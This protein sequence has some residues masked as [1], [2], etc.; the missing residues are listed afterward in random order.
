MLNGRPF[1]FVGVNM[2]GA[3]SDPRIYAC[4]PYMKNPDVELDDWF[5]RARQETNARVIRFWGFQRYTNGGTD[6][7]ALDRVIRLAGAYGFKV[8]PVLENQHEECTRGGARSDTWYAGGYRQQYGGYPLSYPEY[9]RRI[10]ERYR[11]EPAIFAWMLMNEAESQSADDA[12]KLDALYG[13]A[14]DMSAL[15]K[16]LDPNHLVTLGVVGGRQLGVW[17]SYRAL[18]ALPGI[19]FLDY[20]DY[21]ANDE[22]LPGAPAAATVLVQTRLFSQDSDWH[23]VQQDYRPNA[24]GAWET[25][26]GVLP[27]GSQPFRFAGLAFDA[28]AGGQPADIYVDEVQIGDRIYDF[29]DGTAQGWQVDGPATIEAIT[30]TSFAGN[31]ALKL[32]FIKPGG[33]ILKLPA[34]PT[35][36]PGTP[37]TAHV[38]V[39]A[40]ASVGNTGTL[41]AALETARE[42]NKPLVVGESGMT[43]CASESGSAVETP[44]TRAQKFDAKLQ[45]FFAAGG[46][47]YL[48]WAWHPTSDCSYEFTSGDPLNAVLSR[49]AALLVPPT[50]PAGPA[51]SGPATPASTRP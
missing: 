43:A 16:S 35:D 23:W 21:G 44:A 31:H 14:S 5:R 41:A 12:G 30:G 42:L 47:G 48:I 50:P 46:A 27:A 9:V 11:G 40:P 10:V 22:P 1:R 29:E 39:D 25:W 7:Y 20:H 37:I 3:A 33:A 38:Y 51:T 4:G 8:M 49:H 13:F 18:H 34:N 28:N 19:D 2:F 32:H 45:A 24:G 17:G 15:I 26:S 36:K 6:W